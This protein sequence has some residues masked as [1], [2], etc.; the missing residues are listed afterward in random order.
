VR[1]L[2]KKVGAQFTNFFLCLVRVY[3]PKASAL[4]QEFVEETIGHTRG[5][6]GVGNT[7]TVTEVS[8]AAK[9]LKARN[10]ACYSEMRP[11][12]P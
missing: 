1:K 12:M 2:C 6:I 9:T 3:G 7:I 10:D 4:N 8:T 11:K 5:A